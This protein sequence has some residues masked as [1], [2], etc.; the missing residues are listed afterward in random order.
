M[1]LLGIRRVVAVVAVVAVTT[2]VAACGGEDEPAPDTTQAT[3]PTTEA[4][5]SE[6]TF[7]SE[8]AAAREAMERAG[9]DLCALSDTL[10][11]LPTPTA[12]EHV[13]PTIELFAL[14]YRGAAT[15]IEGDDPDSAAALRSAMDALESEADAADYSM[16]FITGEE[17]PPAL[18]GDAFTAAS[19]QLQAAYAERCETPS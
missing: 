11:A 4:P 9:T 3:T 14:A 13:K 2:A 17:P 10:S 19:Q 8:V 15:A 12:P 5:S 16:D 1:T 7:D 6:D 18:R